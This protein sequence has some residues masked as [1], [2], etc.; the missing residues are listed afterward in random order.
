MVDK[1]KQKIIQKCSKFAIGGIPGHR[2][3]EHLFTAKSVISLYEYLDIPLFL[4]TFDISKYFDREILRDAMDSLFEAGITGKLYRLWFMMNKDSQICV[5]T[6]FGMTDTAPTGENVAQGSIGGGIISAL[7]LDKTVG[8]H[9]KGADSE[10]SYGTTRLS[11][12]LYQ[13]D[14]M[15]FSTSVE[16]A[17]KSNI[18]MGQAIKMK[19]LNLNVDKCAAV[20]FGRKKKVEKIRKFIQDNRSLSINGLEVKLKTEEKYLG[21]YFH[22]GGLAKSVEATVNKRFGAALNSIIELKCVVDDFRMHTLGGLISGLDIFNLAIFP[23]LMYNSETWLSISKKTIE[24]L[25]DLQN[26]LMRC[27]L[28]VP[29][30]APTPALNWDLGVLSMEHKINEKK[31]MFFHYISTLDESYLVKE[32]FTIQKKFSFPGFV[33]EFRGLIHLYGLP[34]ILDSANLITKPRWA[35]LVKEAI[36]KKYEDELRNEMTSGHSG[37]GYSKLKASKLIDEKFGLKDYF[38]QMS[39]V[40]ARTHFR[41]RCS[42]T[43]TVKMNQKSNPEYARKLWLCDDCGNVDSQSHIM[44]CPSY[45]TLREE[46]DI[47]NDVDVVHYFQRVLKLREELKSDE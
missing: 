24:R 17:Q 3:Q 34:D 45:A 37:K 2:P 30:S 19:Q 42:I 5:K 1:S 35:I 43:N 13:D 29:K 44:W 14:A 7:N 21:D 12:L 16:G 33:P 41:L 39:L 18:L 40:D 25:D 31:L 36:R 15:N 23:A 26:I 8:G 46:L 22:S 11:P 4:Q 20:V 28:A 47:N 32:I 10:V 9:F 6:G 38:K 27:L